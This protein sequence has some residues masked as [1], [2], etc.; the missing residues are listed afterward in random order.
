MAN[1]AVCL[2]LRFQRQCRY[3]GMT[4]SWF[5]HGSGWLRKL[6]S[7]KTRVDDHPHTF[8]CLQK[9]RQEKEPKKG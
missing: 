8:L 1:R 3:G 5:D 4:R 9:Q 6:R 7:S 2:M